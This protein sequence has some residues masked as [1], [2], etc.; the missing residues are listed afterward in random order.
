MTVPTRPLRSPWR[1]L[2]PALLI[3]SIGLPTSGRT[4]GIEVTDDTGTRVSLTKPPTRVI[5]LAPHLT[6]LMFSIGAGN[7]IVGTVQSADYPKAAT[8]IP[9]VGDSASIDMEQLIAMQPDLVLVW[10]SSNGSTRATRLREL[11]LP[12]FVSEPASLAQIESTV[13]A[14][15]ELTGREDEANTTADP[16]AARVT[17]LKRRDPT[18]HPV[19]VFYQIWGQPIFTVGGRHLISQIIEMCGGRNIFADLPGLAGQVDVESVLAADPD[20]IIASGHDETRPRWLDEWRHWPQLRA[21]QQDQLH[22]VPPALIQR[23]TL[24]VLDGAEM[25]CELISES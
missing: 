3:L 6:E 17:K 19:R 24:R 25:M 18:R 14:L 4:D 9:R 21:V 1:F 7:Q 11:S 12:V 10:Q 20:L 22:F 2:A 23:H 8:R 16:F 15:G 13:R 5:S